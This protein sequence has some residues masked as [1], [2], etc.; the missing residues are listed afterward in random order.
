M[1][2]T[3]FAVCCARSSGGE[4]VTLQA[5]GRGLGG[6]LERAVHDEGDVPVGEVLGDDVGHLAAER[7]QVVV[8]EPA[9]EDPVGVVDL[10]VPHEVDDG[11][12]GR[13]DGPGP[14]LGAGLA[15][16]GGRL[17]GSAVGHRG[18]VGGGLVVGQVGAGVRHRLGHGGDCPISV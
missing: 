4:P 18:A 10:A 9:V 1:S 6:A 7:G 3:G 5:R 11:A 16:A 14:V 2:A 15:G 8:G 13:V 17:L 12:L